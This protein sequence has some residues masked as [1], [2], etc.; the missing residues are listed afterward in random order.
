MSSIAAKT[1]ETTPPRSVAFLGLGVMGYPMA[2][3]LARAGH[4]VTVYNRTSTKSLAWC[5]AF[6]G[7]NPLKHATTPRAAVADAELVFCC[8]GNDEDLRDVVLGRRGP[9]WQSESY[10][11]WVRDDKEL[12]GIIAYINENPVKAG[13]AASHVK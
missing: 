4:D 12:E 1:Y 5:E 2:G 13:L 8:V 11:H 6:A 9:F 10:D 7:G 3:H